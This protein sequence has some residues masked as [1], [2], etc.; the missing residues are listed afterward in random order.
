MRADFKP[1]TLIHERKQ[2]TNNETRRDI[3]ILITCKLTSNIKVTVSV[4]VNVNN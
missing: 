2:N 1:E 3:D 4:N